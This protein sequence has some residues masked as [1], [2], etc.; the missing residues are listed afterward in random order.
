MTS[1]ASLQMLLN[2]SCLSGIPVLLAFPS[3]IH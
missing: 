1:F 3:F 2:N